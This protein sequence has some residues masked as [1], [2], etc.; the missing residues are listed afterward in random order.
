MKTIAENFNGGFHGSPAVRSASVRTPAMTIGM[1]ESAAAAHDRDFL[2]NPAN[3]D[4]PLGPQPD[5]LAIICTC[6][7]LIASLYSFSR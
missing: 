1:G 7:V 3:N 6:F 2:Q 4:Q 5:A